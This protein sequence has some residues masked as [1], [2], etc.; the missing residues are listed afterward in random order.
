MLQGGK[1]NALSLDDESYPP[2]YD[3]KK[4][5]N[6]EP[7]PSPLES[8]RKGLDKNFNDANAFAKPA[9]FVGDDDE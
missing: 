6:Y 8:P 3:P 2:G 7:P 9:G 5:P 4:D 1:L